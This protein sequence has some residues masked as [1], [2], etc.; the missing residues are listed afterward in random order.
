VTEAMWTPDPN[1]PVPRV[2]RPHPLW[3]DPRRLLK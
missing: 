1:E 2:F 3:F